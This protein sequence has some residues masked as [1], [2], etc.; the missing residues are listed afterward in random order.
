MIYNAGSWPIEAGGTQWTS[1]EPEATQALR[2]ASKVLVHVQWPT[3]SSLGVA[4]F[5][6]GMASYNILQDLLA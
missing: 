2:A 5:G 4:L 1:S 3:E 6:E